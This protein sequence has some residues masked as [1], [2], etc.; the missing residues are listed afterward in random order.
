MKVNLH[1][2][3]VFLQF[4]DFNLSISMVFERVLRTGLIDSISVAQSMRK[5]N[6]QFV[7]FPELTKRIACLSPKVELEPFCQI[8]TSYG[9]WILTEVS[10]HEKLNNWTQNAFQLTSSLWTSFDFHH[11]TICQKHV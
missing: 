5:S 2:E 3:F 8:L 4:W 10:N 9:M 7:R 11:R 6:S 1:F